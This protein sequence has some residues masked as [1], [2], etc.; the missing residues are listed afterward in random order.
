MLLENESK[1]KFIMEKL[2]SLYGY[3]SLNN[4]IGLNDASVF[5]EDF[6]CKLLNKVYKYELVNAN[7]KSPNIEL[8]DLF[9]DKNKVCFQVTSNDNNSKIYYTVNNFCVSGNSQKYKKLRIFV[10]S[11]KKYRLDD[12]KITINTYFDKREDLIT[13]TDLIKKI[14]S[15]NDINLYNDIITIINE[16]LHSN[17][18]NKLTILNEVETIYN[19]IDYITN[20]EGPLS[21]E[22]DEPDPEKKI[23]KRFLKYSDEILK[24][25]MELSITYK[26]LFEDIS[27]KT[28]ERRIRKVATYLKAES[29]KYLNKYADPIIAIEEMMKELKNLFIKQQKM[30][31][32]G[33]IKYFLYKHVILCNVFPNPQGVKND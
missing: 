31:D 18:Q 11:N 24:E 22:E 13:I 28:N 2:T 1:L 6:F 15:Y 17:N 32:Q 9:D 10:I 20:T 4:D 26:T 16:G 14:K 29:V 7:V 21:N 33:A 8:I 3:I 19:I 25:Y 27:N 5:C 12:D 23:Y 30:V